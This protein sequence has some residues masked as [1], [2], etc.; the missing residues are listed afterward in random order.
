VRWDDCFLHLQKER[1][2][3]AVAKEENE[4]CPG[5]DTANADD[6]VRHVDCMVLA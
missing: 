2:L 6:A 4:I 3:F 1:I 5:S